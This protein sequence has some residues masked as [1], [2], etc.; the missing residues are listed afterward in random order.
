METEITLQYGK[1][2]K[3]S[4]VIHEEILSCHSQAMRDLFKKAKPL[5]EQYPLADE[6]RKQL[7]DF[8]QTY[9]SPQDFDNNNLEKQVRCCIA[10]LDFG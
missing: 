2:L 3:K 9:S 5:R 1:D 8:I 10:S 6:L 7:K 4:R